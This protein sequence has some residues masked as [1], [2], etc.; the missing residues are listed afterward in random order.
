MGRVRPHISN[1]PGLVQTLSQNTPQPLIDAILAA[2][3]D[4]F[5]AHHG[6]DIFGVARAIFANLKSMR[7]RQGARGR[8][9]WVT[10]VN[11]I[12]S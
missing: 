11:E 12:E 6:I 7:T 3:D 5:Y 2:E 1:Q 8:Y 4:R 10:D 9:V